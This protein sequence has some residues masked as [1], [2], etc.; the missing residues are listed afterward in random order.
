[1]AVGA[2]RKVVVT[3]SATLF[4]IDLTLKT[5]NVPALVDNGAQISC[6]RSDVVEYLHESTQATPDLLFLGRKITSPLE[7][8]WVLPSLQMDVKSGQNQSLWTRA[9]RI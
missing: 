7:S 6:L 5:G 4:W 1:V 8:S 3:P 9:L 2:I